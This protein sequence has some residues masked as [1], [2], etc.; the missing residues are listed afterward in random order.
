MGKTVSDWK[1]I[2]N[3]KMSVVIHMMTIQAVLS[4]EHTQAQAKCD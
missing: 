4:Q 2:W 3:D 1:V